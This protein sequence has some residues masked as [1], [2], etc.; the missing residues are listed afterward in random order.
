MKY[1]QYLAVILVIFLPIN[2]YSEIIEAKK[3]EKHFGNWIVLCEND[4]MIDAVYCKIAS[5]FYENKAVISLEP[6]LKLANQM[7]LVIPNVKIGQSVKIKI[8]KNDI[9]FSKE[10]KT[11]YFGLIPLSPVQKSIML[12]QMK[13]GD[14][15]FLRFNIS[16]IEKEVTVKINLQD[17]HKASSYYSS[18][19]TK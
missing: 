5:K 3:Y 6:S 13:K 19:I 17:F 18:Q 2:S 1:L 11:K 15:L 14:F 8:D 16:G 7:I 4:V 10:V 9:I 12:N